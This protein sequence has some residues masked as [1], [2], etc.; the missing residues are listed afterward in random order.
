MSDKPIA[1]PVDEN[2][3]A[4][5]SK[6]DLSEKTELGEVSKEFSENRPS[7][8]NLTS[9]EHKLV[10]R[11]KSILR[12]LSPTSLKIIDEYVDSKRSVNGWNTGQKVAAITGIQQQ[13]QGFGGKIM[14][15]LFTPKQP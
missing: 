2:L 8:S 10:W 13:R 7:S 4:V 6:V 1:Q 9:D 3:D 12:R 11:A 15:K 14:E 5:L